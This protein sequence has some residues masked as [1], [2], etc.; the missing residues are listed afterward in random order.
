MSPNKKTQDFN[1]FGRD[2]SLPI[3]TSLPDK[4]QRHS[5]SD[6]ELDM[7][8]EG[9]KDMILEFLWIA[10]GVFLGSCPSAIAAM[11]AYADEKNTIKMPIDDLAQLVLFWA[12]LLLSVALGIVA[13]KR[14]T[15]AKSLQKQIRERT[16]GVK[17]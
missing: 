14:N 17:A 2:N 8:C 3:H 9:K 10:I 6:E 7:L 15:R 5:I 12:G 4:I 13:V 11:I 1:A 16:T